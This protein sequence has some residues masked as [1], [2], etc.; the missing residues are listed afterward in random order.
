[1]AK[2]YDYDLIIIGSGVA[3]TAAAQ[4]AAARGIKVAVVESGKWGGDSLNV[5]DIPKR[6][7]TAFSHS[8]IDTGLSHDFGVS[9]SSVR[10]N[11]PT[12]KNWMNR[13]RRASGA[14][15][16]KLLE[17]SGVTC[18]SGLAHFLTPFELSVGKKVL[19][20]PRFIIA[21]GCHLATGD[22]TGLDSCK[23]LT[24]SNFLDI[25]RPPESLAVIGGG[26]TGCIFAEFFASLGT[27]VVIFE[28]SPRL[29]PREDEE[30]G[31][32]IER[33]LTQ[34]KHIKVL[35]QSRVVSVSPSS[36]KSKYSISYL[37]GGLRKTATCDAIFLAAG[38]TPSL[39]LGLDNA[40]VKWD[41][42]GIKVDKYLNTNMRH[43]YAAG[44][45]TGS[46]LPV[47]Y[48]AYSGALASAN[49]LTRNRLPATTSGY[50]RFT[51]T[52]LSVASV[53]LTEEDCLRLG[54]KFKKSISTLNQ[55]SASYTGAE[56]LGFIKL[57][58]DSS[59]K[60]IGATVVAPHAD[61]IVPELA[62]AVRH[63]LSVMELA[64]T[65]VVSSSYAELIRVSA[66]KLIH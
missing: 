31:G 39:D 62:L 35:T 44:S 12:F 61:L 45:C 51:G 4:F 19:T 63:H 42:K 2:K 66:K 6:A 5:S 34:D 20:A 65:P 28:L 15:S 21:S 50:I 8:M 29:L 58:V 40:G 55:I 14:G 25:T 24:P 32:V 46:C 1:M 43:I 18:I 9:T 11:F 10:F 13:A 64:S 53:G 33:S 38:Q 3:G 30:I 26:S 59:D 22:V 16:A 37:R 7:M 60:L 52:H 23:I 17:S 41:E 27:N 57:I 36:G 56:K 54:R 47:E 48:S 49:L